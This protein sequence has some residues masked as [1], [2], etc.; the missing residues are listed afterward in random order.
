M[1][2]RIVLICLVIFAKAECT[3]AAKPL[4]VL[5]LAGQSN[6]IGPLKHACPE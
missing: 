6:T 2:L 5:I 3:Y 1:K 4:K